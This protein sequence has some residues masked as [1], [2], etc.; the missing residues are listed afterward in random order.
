ML[1]TRAMNIEY[2]KQWTWTKSKTKNKQNKEQEQLKQTTINNNKKRTMHNA[3][4]QNKI[5]N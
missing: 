4:E 1:Q 2:F 5:T 3:Q